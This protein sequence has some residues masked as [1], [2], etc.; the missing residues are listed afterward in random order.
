MTQSV[1]FYLQTMQ[2][3]I[4]LKSSCRSRLT[5]QTCP[6][7]SQKSYLVSD[8]MSPGFVDRL[9]M[10][11][12]SKPSQGP[13]FD[14]SLLIDLINRAQDA[15]KAVR[16]Q[17][18]DLEIRFIQKLTAF[19]A[20][21][22][23]HGQEE[24]LNL[25]RLQMK[26]CHKKILKNSSSNLLLI[27]TFAELF[28]K[29]EQAKKMRTISIAEER[30][31]E[32]LHQIDNIQNELKAAVS[33]I[34]LKSDQ[35]EPWKPRQVAKPEFVNHSASKACETKKIVTFETN[36][37]DYHT[38]STMV[39]VRNHNYILFAIKKGIDPPY[40]QMI[41]VG[42]SRILLKSKNLYDGL[43]IYTD[44][45][46]FL[47]TPSLDLIISRCRFSTETSAVRLYKASSKGIMKRVADIPLH[48]F[49]LEK[50][51]RDSISFEVL[52]PQ[53]F[54]AVVLDRTVKIVNF[55]TRS[56]LKTY[57]Y[58]E[59]IVAVRHIKDL[60]FFVVILSTYL[61]VYELSGRLTLSR[62]KFRSPMKDKDFDKVYL[63]AN[64]IITVKFVSDVV[65]DDDGRV[66]EDNSVHIFTGV[67]INQMGV[68]TYQVTL[69]TF[70][71]YQEVYP[72]N[73]QGEEIIDEFPPTVR[74][75]YV[76]MH[77]NLNKLKILYSLSYKNNLYVREI[78]FRDHGESVNYV[79]EEALSEGNG[80][81]VY[82]KGDSL[83]MDTFH[84]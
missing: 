6:S 51:N 29:F 63:M 79:K 60:G 72:I 35:A 30:V 20:A 27:D 62:P 26:K 5:T 84:I 44:A 54:V 73:Y 76:V 83:Y 12:N 2:G 7:L 46:N 36:L 48:L 61:L 23:H 52:H 80:P 57:V 16:V 77:P 39:N 22:D 78:D 25:M 71:L 58:E 15:F 81:F 40:I 43:R 14:H 13:K 59:P 1:S 28:D 65:R 53:H 38:S 17:I 32:I 33:S 70:E 74:I 42:K 24:K 50:T 37:D 68:N 67:K 41:D 3:L 21:D 4:S 82:S 8:L 56:V 9:I 55:L 31:S 49:F 69:K 11:Y 18:D 10:D 34:T 75:W 45:T 64:V 19:C 47:Y 66:T